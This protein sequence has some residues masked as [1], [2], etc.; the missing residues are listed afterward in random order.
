MRRVVDFAD[1]VRFGVRRR[2][3]SS[4]NNFVIER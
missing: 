1:A 4:R 2:A 3:S